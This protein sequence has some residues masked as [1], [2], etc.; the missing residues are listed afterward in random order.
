METL[1][2][3]A[4]CGIVFFAIGYIAGAGTNPTNRSSGQYDRRALD[5]RI[6]YS[7]AYMNDPVVNEMKTRDLTGG[8]RYL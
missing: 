6:N 8:N 3:A 4:V 5:D 7:K 1:I 2:G